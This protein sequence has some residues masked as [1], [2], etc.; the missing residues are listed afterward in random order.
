M[1]GGEV[2]VV[3]FGPGVALKAGPLLEN[4]VASL[5]KVQLVSLLA[6]GRD[7][8][9]AVS[10]QVGSLLQ[11]TIYYYQLLHN[12]RQAFFVRNPSHSLQRKCGTRQFWRFENEFQ[13]FENEFQH[14]ENEFQLI[15]G[16]ISS[17]YA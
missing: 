4:Q 13:H 10:H 6:V 11:P 15:F 9:T 16:R 2:H 3:V 8:F 7:L 1:I 17:I 12:Q 14:F 5:A